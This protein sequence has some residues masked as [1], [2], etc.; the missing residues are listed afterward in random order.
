MRFYDL[1]RFRKIGKVLSMPKMTGKTGNNLRSSITV[2]SV[3]SMIGDT[4]F[5][6][7]PRVCF[8]AIGD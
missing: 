1:H 2:T 6:M 7:L 3:G 5:R 8:E 4:C